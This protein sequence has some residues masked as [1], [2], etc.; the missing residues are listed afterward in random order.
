M[1]RDRPAVT[2][3]ARRRATGRTAAV[4]DPVA[5]RGA[6]L[7]A[8]LEVVAEVGV[9]RTTHRAIAAR[10]GVPLGSTTYYFPTLD[11]LV[12]AALEQ[13]ADAT[14][15]LL[16]HW[17]EEL[18]DRDDDL[19]GAL[20]GLVSDYL[21]DRP[22]A[23]LEC[24]LYLAAAR[25]PVLRPL[26]DAWLDGARDLLAVRVGRDRATALVALVDGAMLAGVV[27]GEDADPAVLEAAFTRLC[28]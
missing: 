27:R 5:R 22:R 28:R 23:L 12:A 17:A 24:E 8:A 10:A 3:R 26:A 16:A 7:A 14:R 4:R 18:A 19:P 13:A 6:I 2:P 1:S 25:S 15:E 9:G 21:A 20:A 11:D